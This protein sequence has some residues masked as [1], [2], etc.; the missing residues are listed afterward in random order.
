M[1]PIYPVNEASVAPY[2]GQMVCA[3]MRD[4]TRYVGILSGCSKGKLMLNGYPSS[5]PGSLYSG[6]YSNKEKQQDKKASSKKKKRN[7]KNK[8]N[9]SA[10][11]NSLTRPPNRP[12]SPS[13]PYDTG[14]LSGNGYGGYGYGG[15][16]Y[17]GGYGRYGGYGYGAGLVLDLALIA[18]LF[19]LI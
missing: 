12:L 8:A 14:G 18:F 17:G 6:S 16:G 9:S 4:G 11:L 15:P 5:S 10:K 13:Y 1:I 3:V 7:P 2:G 19:L